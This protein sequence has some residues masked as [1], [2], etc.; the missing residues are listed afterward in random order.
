MIE[1]I[2]GTILKITRNKTKREE[3]KKSKKRED[4][5]PQK[6]AGKTQHTL[7]HGY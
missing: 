2:I 6:L 1:D 4:L 3:R 7:L 5:E